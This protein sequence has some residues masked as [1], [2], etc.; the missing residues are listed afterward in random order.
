MKTKLIILTAVAAT[1][2]YSCSNDRDEEV[3]KEAIENVKNAKT[4]EKFKLNNSGTLSRE[5]EPTT[6]SDTIRVRGL[7]GALSEDPD[8]NIN[9]DD[10]GDPTTITPPKR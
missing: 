2:L 5:S 6:V 8:T 10:G 1:I 9:P 7:N 4:N 3:K